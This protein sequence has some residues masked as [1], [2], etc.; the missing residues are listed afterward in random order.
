M[1][2]D[3][4]LKEFAEE[5][6]SDA[7]TPGGGAASAYAGV[8]SAGLCMMVA[9]LTI[10]NK[11]FASVHP[12]MMEVISKAELL[13]KRLTDLVEEDAQAFTKVMD[14]FKMPKSTDEE[15][16][17]RKDYLQ[18]ALKKAAEVPFEIADKSYEIFD[19]LDIVVEKGNQN[20]ITDVGVSAH[21][22]YTA[23]KGALLNVY[24]NLSSI[25]D[26]EFTKKYR[27][28]SQNLERMARV[29]VLEIEKK[30]KEKL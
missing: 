7:P 14:G 9:N 13:K 30:V 11:N 27:E 21:C 24:I 2:T 26:E 19:L 1:L 15:K 23:V 10:K 16:E 5:L 20:A 22:A 17:A 29:R 28:D 6:A 18:D 8:M 12:E 3:K 4:N 25:K